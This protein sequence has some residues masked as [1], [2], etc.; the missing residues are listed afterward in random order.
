MKKLRENARHIVSILLE[1]EC[2]VDLEGA[3]P[4]YARFGANDEEELVNA[5][6]QPFTALDYALRNNQPDPRIW[7]VVRGTPYEQDYLQHFG[8]VRESREL[9]C[10]ACEKEYGVRNPNGSHGNCKRHAIEAMQNAGRA[11]N[12]DFSAQ[13]EK[14]KNAPDTAF[15]PDLSDPKNAELKNSLPKS[16]VDHDSLERFRQALF[17]R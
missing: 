4:R 8:L 15:A 6:R 11:K 10:A 3:K 14:I 17:K 2:E 13:I 7:R 12:M 9:A 1:D 5:L 16:T